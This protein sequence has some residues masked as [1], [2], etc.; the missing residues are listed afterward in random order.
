METKQGL[1]KEAIVRAAAELIEKK[2]LDN[3][4][5]QAVAERVGIKTP[6]LYNHIGGLAALNE[7]LALFALHELEDVLRDA[8][9]GTSREDAI[10]AIALAYRGFAKGSPEL[11]KAILRIPAIGTAEVM[12]AGHS[13]VGLLYQVLKPYGLSDEEALH[14]IR[15]FRSAMH[16]FVSLEG[17]GFFK[18]ES[19]VDESY[20]RL[21]AGMISTLQAKGK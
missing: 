8:A 12:D 15:G 7:E 20:R 13:V 11:Y 21:V 14:A 5:L 10:L 6:S 4:T 18:A 19:D 9:I 2:G 1:N 17:V 3:I 16:G